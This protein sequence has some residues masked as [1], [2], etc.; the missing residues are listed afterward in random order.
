MA[1]FLQD[2][3]KE[4]ATERKLKLKDSDKEPEAEEFAQFLQK[5]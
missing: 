2:T 1:K 3:L 4:I 5:V